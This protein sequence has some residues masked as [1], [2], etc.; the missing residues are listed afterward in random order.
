VKK[1]NKPLKKGAKRV[2]KPTGTTESE[3]G[4]QAP[5][6]IYNGFEPSFQGRANK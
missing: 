5:E 6:T 3:A 1:G 2:K 4:F